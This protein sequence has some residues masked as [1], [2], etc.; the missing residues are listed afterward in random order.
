MNQDRIKMATGRIAEVWAI[1]VIVAFTL[2]FLLA[3]WLV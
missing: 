3:W 1:S 2:G